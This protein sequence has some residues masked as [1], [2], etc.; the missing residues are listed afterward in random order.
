MGKSLIDESDPHYAGLYSGIVSTTPE[1]QSRVESHDVVLQ[2]GPFP[3]SANT[4]GFSNNL[5]EDRLIKL[6]PSYCSIRGKVWEGLDFRPVVKKLVQQ[7]KATPLPRRSNGAIQKPRSQVSFEARPCLLS[8]FVYLSWL[9]VIIYIYIY[10]P[11]ISTLTIRRAIPSI[12]R[13]SGLDSASICGPM[14]ASLPKSARPSSD[15]RTSGSRTTASTSANCTTAA[16][17]SRSPRR[18]GSSW[19]G[20]RWATRGA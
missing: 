15:R 2:V 4:G 3:I 17:G 5:A 20:K 11:R 1:V 19:R 6:H 14:T 8:S 10:R 7:L 13:D 18:W 16:S 9:K 12:K